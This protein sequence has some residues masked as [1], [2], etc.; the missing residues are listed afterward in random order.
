MRRLSL[1]SVIECILFIKKG[2]ILG[3]CTMAYA[4]NPSY[5]RGRDGKIIILRQPGQKVMMALFQRTTC[6]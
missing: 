3:L 5:F 1:E 6:S 4:C 2:P